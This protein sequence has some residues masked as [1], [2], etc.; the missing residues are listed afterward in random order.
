MEV[1]IPKD[2]NFI[3]EILPELEKLKKRTDE[4]LNEYLETL[5]K[6]AHRERLKFMVYREVMGDPVS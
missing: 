5:M 4:I 2:D 6:R 3:R 1:Y